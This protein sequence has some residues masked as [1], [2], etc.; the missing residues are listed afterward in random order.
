MI[1]SIE[2]DFRKKII[3]FKFMQNFS[4]ILDLFFI[5]DYNILYYLGGHIMTK[6]FFGLLAFVLVLCVAFIGCPTED[7]KKEE[8]NKQIYSHVYS[9]YF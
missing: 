6:R 2:F 5:K 8:G 1:L 4:D 3:F 9:G 7:E